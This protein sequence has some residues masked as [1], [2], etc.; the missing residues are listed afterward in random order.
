M[1]RL[2]P[3]RCL[4][5]K[6]QSRGWSLSLL[7]PGRQTMGSSHLLLGAS[8]FTGAMKRQRQLSTGQSIHTNSW[9]TALLS[10]AL[11]PLYLSL[12]VCA[13]VS[14][15]QPVPFHAVS[16]LVS[17][18]TSRAQRQPEHHLHPPS[19]TTLTNIY[20]AVLIYPGLISKRENH[21]RRP[22]SEKSMWACLLAQTLHQILT[23]PPAPKARC[24][25]L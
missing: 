8:H 24:G 23:W 14:L 11:S 2:V 20:S 22:G 6:D 25:L 16:P 7:P 15:P 1:K 4:I 9:F 18:P 12:P 17:S 3:W 10:L 19:P 5:K 13:Y 21:N